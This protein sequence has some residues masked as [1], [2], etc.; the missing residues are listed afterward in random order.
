MWSWT[1]LNDVLLLLFSL[2]GFFSAI[3]FLVIVARYSSCRTL[4]I[5][6]VGNACCAGLLAT[7]STI[8]QAIN[9]LLNRCYPSQECIIHAYL[10]YV[11]CGALLHA[12]CLQ[13]SHRLWSNVFTVGVTQ[14]RYLRSNSFFAI[15][16]AI[17]W[18]F[19]FSFPLLAY[20]H[21]IIIPSSCIC[22][23]SLVD[24]YGFMIIASGIYLIPLPIII[25][26]YSII[27][28]HHVK[29]MR[30]TARQS[31]AVGQQMRRELA[32]LKRITIPVLILF[33][34]GFPYIVFFIQ[35]QFVTVP[36]PYAQRIATVFVIAGEASVMIFNIIIIEDV[37]QQLL[38]FI[39]CRPARQIACVTTIQLRQR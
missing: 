2:V 9:M 29:T 39:R 37:R 38:I 27:L 32:M 10:L 14:H 19:S 8:I 35:A 25:I 24:I 17:Q 18:I 16:I 33:I 23:I 11:S 6:L 13:A 5:L 36:Y 26:I 7:G 31:L 1:V 12:S 28:R 15:C 34:L 30:T 3:V 21:I 4:P 20:K 22:Q